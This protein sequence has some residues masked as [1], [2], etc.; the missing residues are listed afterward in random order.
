MYAQ[1]VEGESW[2]GE[3][4]DP[5]KMEKMSGEFRIL[6]W[7][8]GILADFLLVDQQL[9]QMYELMQSIRKQELEDGNS[10]GIPEGG[11]ESK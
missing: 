7:A 2:I 11:V 4:I 9:G 5:G 1:K 8:E 6:Q 3:K 10:D